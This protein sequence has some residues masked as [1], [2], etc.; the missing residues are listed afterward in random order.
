[1]NTAK[2]IP[3]DSSAFQELN[4]LINAMASPYGQGDIVRFNLL[5][6][7]IYPQLSRD[8]KRRA[9]EFVDALIAGVE[10]EE[11]TSQIYG[12]V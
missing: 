1:M 12:V 6:Q 5:Y 11:W 9:E 8:E 3:T 2:S 10:K 7:R 4:T